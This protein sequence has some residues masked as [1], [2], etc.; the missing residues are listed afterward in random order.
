MKNDEGFT[1]IETLTALALVSII[2]TILTLALS[3]SLGVLGKSRDRALF[4]VR[5]LRADSLIRNRIGAVAIPYWETPVLETGDSSVTIPWYQ[6]ERSGYVR[7]LAEDDS[8]IMETGE[9]KKTER[10]VLLSGL[11]EV[12]FSILRNEQRT[13]CGI[14][15]AYSHKQKIYHTLSAFSTFPIQGGAP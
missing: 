10:I 1:L 7:L 6:G 2:M 13:P 14:D 15:V 12:G 3:S 8:L 5:L 11:E 9:K 4:G